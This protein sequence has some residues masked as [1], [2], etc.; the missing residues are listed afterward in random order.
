MRCP[1]YDVENTPSSARAAERQIDA[2]IDDRPTRR[3][4]ER[5]ECGW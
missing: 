1:D 4:I 2:Y 3:E 5:E